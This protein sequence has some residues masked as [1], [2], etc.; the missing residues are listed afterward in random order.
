M[1]IFLGL[2]KVVDVNHLRSSMLIFSLLVPHPEQTHNKKTYKKTFE[3]QNTI[4]VNDNFNVN[5]NVLFKTS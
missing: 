3:T 4:C 1:L 2:E 5:V